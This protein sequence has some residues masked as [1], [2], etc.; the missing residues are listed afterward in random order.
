MTSPKNLS[1]LEYNLELDKVSSEIKKK[2]AKKVLIQLPDGFKP[3]ATAI[4]NELKQQIKGK[5]EFYIW[6]DSCYGACDIPIAESE[7]LGI[8]M[9]V[10]F[11]HSEF[12]RN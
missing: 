6:F 3:Y 1:E 4:V 9:I 7:K 12:H 5:T 2:K 8:D 10:Q 11:G